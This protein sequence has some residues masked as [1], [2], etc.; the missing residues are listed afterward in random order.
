[1]ARRLNKKGSV[2]DIPVAIALL[3]SLVITLMVINLFWDNISPKLTDEFGDTDEVV[4]MLGSADTTFGMFDMIFMSA[5]I[6]GVF[7]MLILVSITIDASPI[8]IPIYLIVLIVT[9]IISAII[10]NT[11]DEFIASASI[12]DVASSYPMAN[13]VFTNLPL[14]VTCLGAILIII[15]YIK[16]RGANV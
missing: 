1:M 14:I 7:V 5:L 12:S 6:F 11:Y 4:S 2:L 10:S 9:V 3:F 13:V 15:T 16:I 8:Y